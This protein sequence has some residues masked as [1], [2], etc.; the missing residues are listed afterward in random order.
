[1]QSSYLSMNLMIGAAWKTRVLK[2]WETK[3]W[4]SKHI[5]GIIMV[6]FACY[7]N[8]AFILCTSPLCQSTGGV[9]ST[10]PSHSRTHFFEK[11]FIIKNKLHL[12]GVH[13]IKISVFSSEMRWWL[14]LKKYFLLKYFLYIFIFNINIL[15]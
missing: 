13:N 1:M 2:G 11:F 14:F 5:R 8:H 12:V 9:T 15:K 4:I 10:C 3:G 7:A 6:M